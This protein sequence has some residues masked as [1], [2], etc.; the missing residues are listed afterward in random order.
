VRLALKASAKFLAW[1]CPEGVCVP[2]IRKLTAER[3]EDFFLHHRRTHGPASQRT[4]QGALRNFL[5]FSAG[6]EWTAPSLVGA[7]PTIHVYRLSTIPRGLSDGQIAA[8]L[9]EVACRDTA[10]S[11]RDWALLLLFAT[12]GVRRGQVAVLRLV[13]IDWEKRRIYFAAHKG[14]KPVLHALTAPVATA[15]ARYVDGVRPRIPS[16]ALFVRTRAPHLPLGPDA[17]S[18]AIRR[19]LAQAGVVS[20]PLGPHAFRHA[21]AT[22]LLCSGQSLKVVA[23]LLGHRDLASAA[24]YAK[25][26]LPGL[27]RVAVEWP[28]V[29]R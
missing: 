14:G 26:D 5:R 9:E 17:V 19:R 27:R 13:D 15:L 11:V 23:D 20:T 24:I 4:M 7:V 1:V 29:L 8:A 28:E 3:I 12:Y 21:F 16:D 6:Q 18:A 22:R 2:S 10:G 25:V